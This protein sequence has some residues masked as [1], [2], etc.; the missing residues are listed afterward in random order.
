MQSGGR[1]NESSRDKHSTDIGLEIFVLFTTVSEDDIVVKS[2]FV[3]TNIV[4]IMNIK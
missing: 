3:K 1:L 2:T 4:V